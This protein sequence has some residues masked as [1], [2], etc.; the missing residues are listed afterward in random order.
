MLVHVSVQ[1]IALMEKASMSLGPGMH[2]VTGETGA[3]KSLLIDAIN[4]L[5]GARADLD[6]L[7]TGE[8]SARV[9]ALFDI[10]AAPHA[11]AWL[12]ENGFE[13]GEE[14]ILARELTDRGRAICRIDGAMVPLAQL[15]A[16]G[17]LLVDVHAQH[18]HQSL[19]QES[20]HLSLLDRFLGDTI[21]PVLA[22]M[23]AAYRNWREA[24]RALQADFGTEADR[25]RRLDM[26]R[27]QIQEITSAHLEEGE[28]ERLLAR[29]RVLQHAEKVQQALVDAYG[30]LYEGGEGQAAALD[31]LRA[32]CALM[33]GIAPLDERFEALAGR[34][35]DCFYQLED[36]C[37]QLR[38]EKNAFAFEPGELESLEE[39]LEVL[40][41]L[42]RKYGPTI[43]EV[44]AYVQKAMEERDRL[45]NSA[46]LIEQLTRKRD[47]LEKSMQQQAEK[48]SLLRREGAKVLEKRVM[49]ELAQLGLGRAT[50]SI[51]FGQ[52]QQMRENGMD[53]VR[54]M[55]SA[56]PGEAL[57]P[58]ARVASG[59]EVARIMLALKTV[60][61]A[62]DDIPTLIFDEIDTGIS[63]RA[64]QVVA[65]KCWMLGRT[66]QV[67]C[68]SHLTQMAAMADTHWL[69]EKQ[70]EGDR[71][72]TH[73]Q[74]LD[75]EGRVGQLAVM[76]SGE[77][78]S[79]IALSHA[80]KLR[81]DALARQQA[82]SA[83]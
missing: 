34:L 31:S 56:N 53:E 42:K 48:L 76:A 2:V 54:F 24:C 80:R 13:A 47:A 32:S 38:E 14:V 49:E 72:V 75:E 11:R 9:E 78:V 52:A 45:E 44:C 7:R 40:R 25:E 35:N 67:M 61:S 60:F 63:G 6:L 20:A 74:A 26:L 82:L 79:P 1:N 4:L 23:A 22:D 41:G 70:I 66:R 50:F 16:L 43:A 19:L 36:V 28:E 37:L 59:G 30:A 10:S 18:E 57:K 55:M 3:G 71:T 77:P 46:Q 81:E 29:R 73:L 64:A 8:K 68:V 69:V 5:L 65:E 58:L 27:Y 12:E 15:R 21:A 62:V 51:T 83:Q 17:A 33:E 39:R